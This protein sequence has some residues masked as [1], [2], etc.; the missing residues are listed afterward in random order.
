M[1]PAVSC[2]AGPVERSADVPGCV[3]GSRVGVRRWTGARIA[4]PFSPLRTAR[5]SC[6]QVWKPATALACGYWLVMSST[7][8]GL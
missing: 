6:F 4:R 7:L 1:S 3:D 2:A 8:C 5:P